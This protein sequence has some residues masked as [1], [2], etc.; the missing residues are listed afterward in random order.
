MNKMG[1]RAQRFYPHMLRNSAPASTPG[2]ISLT[3][4]LLNAGVWSFAGYGFSLV[5][6]LGSN[7]LMTR[8]LVPEMFGVIAIAN[9]LIAGLSLFS[10]IGLIQSVIQ[11]RRGNDPVFLNTAWAIQILRG[12]TLWI[13]ALVL[14]ALGFLADRIEFFPKG[15]AYANPNLPY[16]LAILSFNA[17]VAGAQSTKLFEARRNLSLGRVTGLQIVAQLAGLSVMIG[18]AI[19]DRS[20]WALVAGSICSTTIM[21]LTSHAWLPGNPNRWEWDASAFREIVH[22]GRWIF[23]SS[24]LGYFVTNGDRLLLGGL[25]DPTLLGIYIIAF[26][27]F[28]SVDRIID[29]LSDLLFSALS[30]TVRERPAK[31]KENYY[32]AH[33][34]LGPFAYLC[35]GLLMICGHTLI[36]M[37][38]DPRYEQAG[39]MLQ[40]LAVA[41]LAAPSH[42][43]FVCLLAL[44]LPKLSTQ[45]TVFRLVSF[46]V[47]VP[48]AFH[49]FGL[50]GALWAM[51]VSYFT[52]AP[53]TIFYRIKFGLFDLP[54]ELLSILAWIAG[55]LIGHG[56]N[57]AM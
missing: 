46:Y 44:G 31:L 18:W 25:I 21:T 41:L 53:T 11:N 10:D 16:V 49:Y 12:A 45:V 34:F 57:M 47:L 1:K 35:S 27:I 43:A 19:I 24:I 48:L 39:W 6:R 8:L 51:V 20:I 23:I 32:R 33:A 17:L 42:L 50:Q 40:I 2:R 56:V 7:L 55:M 37:L 15:T 54:K 38:Y 26:V 3:Q 13:V 9:M 29:M 28:S 5:F 22:F 36:V 52:S 14:S 30:E 4:R